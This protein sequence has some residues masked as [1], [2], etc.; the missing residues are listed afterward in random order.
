MSA[1]SEEELSYLQSERRLGRIATVGADGTPHVTPVGWSYNQELDT[2]DIGGRDFAN[3][4]KFRDVARSGKAAIVVDDVLPPWQPRGVEIRG[5]AEAVDGTTPVIRI[6]PDR[7]R[8]WG[9][10]ATA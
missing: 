2:I 8:S 7:V 9:L 10:D 5:R 1:F 3:T 6:H 4:K